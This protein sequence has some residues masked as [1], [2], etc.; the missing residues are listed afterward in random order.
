MGNQSKI[1]F[2]GFEAT[3]G[4]FAP[5]IGGILQ[6][7]SVLNLRKKNYVVDINLKQGMLC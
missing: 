7:I 2:T 6:I 4:L 1:I 5:I 3:D